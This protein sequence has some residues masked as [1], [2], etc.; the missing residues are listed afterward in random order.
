M[1]WLVRMLVIILL[2]IVVG[3]GLL[4]PIFLFLSDFEVKI[5]LISLQ[6]VFGFLNFRV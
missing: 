5:L 2:N 3:F 1:H 4:H 6:N